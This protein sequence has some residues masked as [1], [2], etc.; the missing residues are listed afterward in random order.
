MSWSQAAV[1]QS[2]SN[3]VCLFDR[4]GMG[5]SPAQGGG[6]G[7]R[8]APEQDAQ[9]MLA[10]LQVL[11]EPGPYLLTGWSYGGL[12][13]RTAAAQHPEQVAGMVLVDASSPLQPHG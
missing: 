13:A 1:A 2:E 4:P 5:L 8:D 9:E 6:G 3:R 7:F 12:V 10:M 11:G